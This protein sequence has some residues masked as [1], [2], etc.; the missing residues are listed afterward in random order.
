MNENKRDEQ[1]KIIKYIHLIA[2]CIVLYSIM[3]SALRRYFKNCW[4]KDM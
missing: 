4:L 1:H 3:F 2:N